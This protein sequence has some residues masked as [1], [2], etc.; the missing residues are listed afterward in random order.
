M[1]LSEWYMYAWL[2][3][4]RGSIVKS[5]HMQIPFTLAANLWKALKSEIS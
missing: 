3:V 5:D 2:Q 1:L 4:D